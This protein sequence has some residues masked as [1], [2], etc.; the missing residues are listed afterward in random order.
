MIYL[1]ESF[2]EASWSSGG[3]IKKRLFPVLKSEPTFRG[4][5]GEEK[6]SYSWSFCPEECVG[7]NT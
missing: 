6:P 4:L 3:T 5:R 2:L 7:K 1:S